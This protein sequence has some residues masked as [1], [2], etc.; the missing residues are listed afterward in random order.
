MFLEKCPQRPMLKHLC[1]TN[2]NMKHLRLF[3]ENI[4]YTETTNKCTSYNMVVRFKKDT[5]PLYKFLT[6]FFC[7]NIESQ[8]SAP[9]TVKNKRIVCKFYKCV[10]I[11]DEFDD[12]KKF[13]S[14]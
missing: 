12:N 3:V 2:A 8:V 11:C 14:S 10:K 6:Y 7:E 13:V 4:F 1:T 9:I 5:M